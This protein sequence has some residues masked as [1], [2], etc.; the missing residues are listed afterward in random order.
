MSSRRLIGATIIAIAAAV[1]LT[2]PATPSHSLQGTT[3]GIDVDPGAEP[4]NSATALGTI[5]ACASVANTAGVQTS[6]DV[7]V[8]QIPQGV[9]FTGFNYLL[10]FDSTRFKITAHD[11]SLLLAAA[12]GTAVDL[13]DSVPDTESPHA[14]APVDLFSPEQGPI[15]GVL[16]RY[17][18]EV[19][20]GAPS[21][22]AGLS[23]S[24]IGLF[25]SRGEDIPVDQLLPGFLALGEACPA[26]LPLPTPAPDGG[27]APTETPQTEATP[28]ASQTATAT[29]TPGTP[30]GSA[31]PAPTAT[32]GP[33]GQGSDSDN[34]SGGSPWP[35]VAGGVGAAAAVL[36]AA[37]IVWWRRRN[38]A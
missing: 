18:L 8:N 13:G 31:T 20:P 29:G 14:V 27:T 2:V 22:L 25:D 16:G 15:A 17:T 9:D 30:A 34:G 12:G 32:A 35:Y 1:T 24:A 21:G 7:F 28:G 36:A 6:I 4:A 5:E 10:E 3:V 38:A 11:H 37:G 23:L 19:L 33:G 26:E